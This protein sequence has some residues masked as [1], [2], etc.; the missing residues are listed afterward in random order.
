VTPDEDDGSVS[1]VIKVYRP[2]AQHRHGG[3]MTQHLESLVSASCRAC[4]ARV[5]PGGV[6]VGG[7]RVLSVA[8]S[9]K[10][11]ACPPASLQVPAIV[12]ASG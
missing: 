3:I 8:V 2:D 12:I 4:G 1:F 11:K 10:Y 5:T 6:P 7:G 9:T